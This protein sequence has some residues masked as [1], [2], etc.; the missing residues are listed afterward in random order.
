MNRH[1]PNCS[2]SSFPSVS[3]LAALY[4]LEGAAYIVAYL[5][6]DH[7]ESDGWY[8]HIVPVCNNVAIAVLIDGQF[9]HYLTFD[10]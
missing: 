8:Y 7:D 10:C 3:N 9:D 1:Y 6:S 4:S 2:V 5:L